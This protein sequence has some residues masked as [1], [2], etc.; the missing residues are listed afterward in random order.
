MIPI[1][2]PLL[3]EDEAS[4]AREVVLSGWVSQGPQVAAFERDFATL[5]GAPHASAVCNCTAAL[6]LALAALGIAPGDEVITASHSFIAT[7]NCIRYCGASPVFVDIDPET[8]NIDPAR[9]AEAI[10]SRTRAILAVHQMGMPCDLSALAALAKRHDLT[11][12]E[13]A[14]C[15]VGSQ[16]RVDGQWDWIGKP[17]GHIACFSFHPRKVITTGEGGMLTTSSPELDRSFKL[18]RQH[19][20]TVPDT[21][22]HSSQ[23]VIFE[24]Y[25]EVGFNYRMTDVQA[26]VGRKQLQ[27]LP[28]LLALRRAHASRYTDLLGNI[29]GLHLPTE[30]EWARSNW[31]SYCVRLPDHVDQR[32][33]MQRLLDKG[34]ATRRGIMCGH[35]EAP[36]VNGEQRHDLRQSELAQDHSILLPIYAQMRAD[37]LACVADTLRTALQS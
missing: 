3:D 14:A 36:Y 9:V 26:A 21:V 22:R 29:E 6:H 10:T 8:Y 37:D 1:A 24:D 18:L 13:D 35:R 23:K 33:V 31:Q 20:M 17:H 15:A 5:V 12:I 7:A 25:L 27:R 28:V 11:L 19:G 34:I 4:A 2:L 32:D 16:I 30:P